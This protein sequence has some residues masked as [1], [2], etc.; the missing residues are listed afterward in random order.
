MKQCV[1]A[2]K[3]YWAEENL[4]YGLDVFYCGKNTRHQKF[5]DKTLTLKLKK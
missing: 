3:M 4:K 2:I 5:T 1:R